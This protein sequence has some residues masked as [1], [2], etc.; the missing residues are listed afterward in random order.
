MASVSKI[1]NLGAGRKR[2]ENA[3]NIDCVSSTGP[4]IVHD[5]KVFPWPLR[6][7]SFKEIHAYDVLEHLDDSVKVMNEIH[8]ISENGA[9]ISITVPHFSSGNAFTDPT[10]RHYFGYRSFEYFNSESPFSFYTDC[11]FKHRNRKLIFYPSLINKVIWRLAQRWPEAYE[12]RW[13]WIFPAWYL[14]FELE[15]VH[16]DTPSPKD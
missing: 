5:L 15:A 11:R 10:H 6:D 8:R 2:L 1:L 9:Q 13:A 4:E 14:S 3:I 12:R 7:R 16:F